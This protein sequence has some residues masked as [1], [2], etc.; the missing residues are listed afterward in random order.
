MSGDLFTPLAI[1][2]WLALAGAGIGLGWWATSA[3]PSP[4]AVP[5]EAPELPMSLVSTPSSEVPDGE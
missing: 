4:M 5:V 1:G 2:A 3:P